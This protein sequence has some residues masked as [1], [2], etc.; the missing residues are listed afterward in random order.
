M[1]LANFKPPQA[2][3]KWGRERGFVKPA[4]AHPLADLYVAWT[5]EALYLGLYSLDIVESAYYRSASVPKADRALLVVR[6]AGREIV[7]ARLGAGREPLV[8]EP[9]VRIENSSGMGHNVSNVAAL[10]IPAHLF[11]RDLLQLGD[12]VELDCSLDTHGRAYRVE[13]RGRFPLAE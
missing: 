12:D 6:I 3:R 1:P 9:R 4:T 13:W 5:P 8:N 11:G 2:L 10:E 7:R